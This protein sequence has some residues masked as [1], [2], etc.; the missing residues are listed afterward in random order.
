MINIRHSRPLWPSAA[1]AAALTVIALPVVAS[2]QTSSVAE[3]QQVMDAKRKLA[4][5][6]PRVA[7]DGNNGFALLEAGE[8]ALVLG[9]ADT[10]YGFLLRAEQILPREA[11]VKSA[12]GATA[13]VLGKPDQALRYFGE[14]QAMGAVERTYLGERGLAYD[15]AGN[16]AAAQADYR[17]ALSAKPGDRSITRA[18]ALSLGISGNSAAG[19]TMLAPLLAAQDRAAWRA[20]AFILAM[21]GDEKQANATVDAVMPAE[22]AIAIKPY[23]AQ[24]DRLTPSQKAAAVHL[25]RFPS[26]DLGSAPVRLA[27]A[28]PAQQAAASGKKPKRQRAKRAAKSNQPV[29]IG[30]R[31]AATTAPLA[32]PAAAPTPTPVPTPTPAAAPIQKPVQLAIKTSPPVP[33]PTVRQGP[34]ASASPDATQPKSEPAP[35]ITSV[36]LAASTISSQRPIQGETKSLPDQ[37]AKPGFAIIGQPPTTTAATANAGRESAAYGPPTSASAASAPLPSLFDIVAALDV[38]DSKPAGEA[39][40]GAAELERI[41]QETLARQAAE[42]KREEA[43]RIKAAAAAEAKRKAD[44]AAKAKAANPARHWVQVATGADVKALAFDYRRIAKSHPDLF[45]GKSGWTSEWGRTRRLVVGPFDSL[46]DAKAWD[47]DYRK[48][49]GDSFTWSSSDGLEVEKIAGK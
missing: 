4:S 26:G 37:G 40:L 15:L 12:L 49:G 43:A 28:E 24:M 39:A 35:A 33:Q 9:D 45:K 3:T 46:K 31:V 32:S 25:G 38:A 22:L 47:A 27:S 8:A 19:L 5:A 42:D 30:T 10:A 2:A 41:R 20:R 23:L 21:N 48:A 1:L 7:A 18:Y 13:I 16:P 17:A 11:R 36:P 34:P 44:A 6:L 14:A 29:A